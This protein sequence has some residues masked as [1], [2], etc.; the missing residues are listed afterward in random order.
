MAKGN[1]LLG[2]A[3]GK[4]GSLVFST[5]DGKQVVK[6]K[7]EQVSNPRTDGQNV[8]RAVFAS[9]AAAAS[10][11][12]AI[13]DH[14][15][16]SLKYGETSVR[17]FRKIN[18]SL[19]RNKAINYS[20][21]TSLTP[22]GGTIYPAPYIM[23]KGTL[24]PFSFEWNNETNSFVY[25]P[26]MVLQSQAELS[27]KEFFEIFPNVQ[28][29]DQ[30]TVCEIKKVAGTMED[31]DAQFIF[32]YNRI[33]LAPQE[34]FDMY[35]EDTMIHTQ[36]QWDQKFFDMAKTTSLDCLIPIFNDGEVKMQFGTIVNDEIEGAC[37]VILSR[38]VDGVWTRSNASMVT[39]RITEDQDND[40]AVATYGNNVT[41]I[42]G[43]DEYLNQ[44]DDNETGSQAGINGPYVNAQISDSNNQEEFQ[45]SSNLRPG[46]SSNFGEITYPDEVL[47]PQYAAQAYG[48]NGVYPKT[49][50]CYKAVSTVIRTKTNSEHNDNVF[51]A[52]SIEEHL[53]AENQNFRITVEWSNGKKTIIRWTAKRGDE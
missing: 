17:H 14:S 30:I 19:I 7:P 22:K 51:I 32:K 48:K 29:G 23:S 4:V 47:T 41:S 2:K 12:K 43:N 45:Y 34:V 5:L 33:V 20:L 24:A 18:L 1:M 9:V 49:V 11:M 46:E 52:G 10:A 42:S 26:R 39:S 21:D 36:D 44:A 37:A 16:Q 8:Q 50:T 35:P 53:T 6:S 15:F 31:L 28:P 3:R 13:I 38:L 27:V 25:N 40:A